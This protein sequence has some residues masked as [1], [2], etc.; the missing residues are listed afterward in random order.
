MLKRLRVAVVLASVFG[1]GRVRLSDTRLSSEDVLAVTRYTVEFDPG[2][3]RGDQ[4]PRPPSALVLRRSK[5]ERH[6]GL[7]AAIGLVEQ[8]HATALSMPDDLD[9]EPGRGLLHVSRV[10]VTHRGQP[11]QL[12]ER[13]TSTD[14]RRLAHRQLRPGVARAASSLDDATEATILWLRLSGFPA[15]GAARTALREP[16]SSTRSRDCVRLGDSKRTATRRGRPRR[17]GFRSVANGALFIKLLP[18]AGS[19]TRVKGRTA[20]AA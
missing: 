8:I 18:D 13:R 6:D 3:V 11:R 16:V 10:R 9:S 19:G 12:L 2:L 4:R 14:R 5:R 1:D 20:Q 15:L 17:S 7:G